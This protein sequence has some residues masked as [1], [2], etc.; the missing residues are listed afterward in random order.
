M[1]DDVWGEVGEGFSISPK[2]SAARRDYREM[3]RANRKQKEY[4][5]IAR[6]FEKS[7]ENPT[8]EAFKEHP[9]WNGARIGSRLGGV[10]IWGQD[11]W[12]VLAIVAMWIFNL[13]PLGANSVFKIQIVT[14]Q[15]SLNVQPPYLHPTQPRQHP[16]P[17]RKYGP[18]R[19]DLW[20]E[21]ASAQSRF[22]AVGSPAQ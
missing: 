21:G 8:S 9:G 10:K 13:R 14:S 15:T 22:L 12:G 17:E 2:A 7:I 6:D 19:A 5:G 1:A 3:I 11:V 20:S 16:S 18:I 4:V